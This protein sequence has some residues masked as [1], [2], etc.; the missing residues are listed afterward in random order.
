MTPQLK[1]LLE[2][3]LNWMG[4]NDYE[5]GPVGAEIYSEIRKTLDAEEETRYID[6]TTL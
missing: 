5:C 1:T 6:S 4:E 3:I 2:D